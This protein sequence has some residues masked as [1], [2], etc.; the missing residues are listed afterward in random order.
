MGPDAGPE[1]KADCA[2][3]FGLCCVALPLTRSVDFPVD[4]PAGEPCRNLTTHFSCGIHDRLR[5]E[6]WKGC[7]VFD[8]FGAGQRVSRSTYAGVSW[9]ERPGTAEEM[10]AV[11]GVVRQLHELL[12]LLAEAERR[13]PE[14][15][16]GRH[17]RD[18]A[19]RVDAAA[20]GTPAQVLGTEVGALRAEAG[21][22]FRATSA[23]LRGNAA[24]ELPL[25]LAGADLRGRDLARADLR[26]R[27][28]IR[29]DLRD[30]DLRWADLLGA[31][32]RDADLSGADLTDAI[33]LTQ[34]QLD[35]AR[36]ASSTTLGEGL[37][38]PAF[39]D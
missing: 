9:R 17:A 14:A 8:C 21:A 24:P 11:L 31:D 25:D 6:G 32:L 3:C 15:A 34:P 10:Y 36:G 28:L 19:G 27:L 22:L 13:A 20:G 29:A 16:L 2:S 23:R 38:T 7:A 33:F 5:D 12:V 37:Q 4:K 18:L 35:A 39:W 26:G 1:L 30:A